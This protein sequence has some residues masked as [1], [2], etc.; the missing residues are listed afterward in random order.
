MKRTRLFVWLAGCVGLVF[1]SS[2]VFA[3]PPPAP[4]GVVATPG[5]GQVTLTWN[6]VEGAVAYNV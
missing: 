1:V 3:Q 6:L 4:T 5:D 2:G